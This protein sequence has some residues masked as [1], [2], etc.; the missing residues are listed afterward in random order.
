MKVSYRVEISHPEQHIASVFLHINELNQEKC[1][2]F[3]PSW[4]PGSYLMRE[5]SRHLRMIKVTNP[6][7]VRLSISQETKGQWSIQSK[8]ESILEIEYEIYLHELTVRTSHIDQS[9]A[10]LHGPSYLMGVKGAENLSL[11]IEFRFPP[12]WSKISTSLKSRA[13]NRE[14]FLYISENYDELLDCPVEIGCHETDGFIVNGK[15]HFLA[16]YGE[17]YP[18]K[19]D[20]KNDFKKIVEAVSKEMKSM[21]YDHYLFITH[22]APGLYGGLEHLNSTA[23][24]FDAKKLNVRKD[25][26][27]FL[28][29][30]CHE[31]FHLWNVKR[32]RPIE[33]GPFD[34]QN[35]NYTTMLW[36]AEGL[37]SFVDEWFIYRAGLCSLE[38][39]LEMQKSNFENYLNTPGRKFHS[40]EESSFNAW[41][42]L[43]RP[44]ENSRNSSISYYLKGGLVFFILHVYFSEKG[45][46]LMSFIEALWERFKRDPKKGLIKNEIYEII[47]KMAGPE[48]A[49]DFSWMVETT[50]DIPFEKACEKMGIEFKWQEASILWHGMNTENENGRVMVKTVVLD[51]PSYKAGVN[52]GD[53]LIFM[54]QLRVSKDD[55]DQWPVRLLENESYQ[56]TVARLGAKVELNIILEKAPKT[57]KELSI[58]NR[59]KIEQILKM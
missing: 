33:L 41:I 25:Y 59:E 29:L 53:E 36:L 55:V 42:K 8:N 30:I 15:E 57:L 48:V 13:A 24:Q 31:Y 44:D 1:E 39:Y 23:L 27:Q 19:Q 34:Y 20:L 12:S 10:Y 51:S 37:T 11:P 3:L 52:A 22:F 4:S 35:E 43:Y 14:S 46:S 16:F 9:H 6:Q 2:I 26:L 56:L 45:L 40:L 47:E 49:E 38:E 58:K 50:R 32:I 17:T 28:C 7:G 5:Y 18:H 54:N 21:P